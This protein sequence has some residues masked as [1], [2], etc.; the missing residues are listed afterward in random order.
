MWP[1]H[2]ATGKVIAFTT[3]DCAVSYTTTMQDA[4]HTM[5][6]CTQGALHITLHTLGLVS[7]CFHHLAQP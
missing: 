6:N 5:H 7:E 3:I 4:F 2:F 1:F